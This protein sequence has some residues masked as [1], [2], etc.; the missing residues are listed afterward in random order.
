MVKENQ[1]TNGMML[2]MVQLPMQLT[3]LLQRLQISREQKPTMQL[4]LILKDLVQPL[5]LK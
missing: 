2:Q 3:L 5:L 1:P 4:L